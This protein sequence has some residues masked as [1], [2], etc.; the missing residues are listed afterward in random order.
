MTSA[1]TLGAEAIISA[2][3]LETE[4]MDSVGEIHVLRIG[5]CWVSALLAWLLVEVDENVFGVGCLLLVGVVR[6]GEGLFV[7]I[8]C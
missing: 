1:A 7:A 3:V 4:L 6:K 5:Y 2:V 8:F